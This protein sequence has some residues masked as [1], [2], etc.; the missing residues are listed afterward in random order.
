[1][2]SLVADILMP[3]IGLLLGSGQF[4]KSVPQPLRA[5]PNATLAEAKEAGAATNQL[6]AVPQHGDRVPHR[7][8]GGVL[9]IASLNRLYQAPPATPTTKACPYCI[10]VI[11]LA[12]SVP[13]APLISGRRET[14]AVLSVGRQ[15]G[16]AR[17]APMS[18]DRSVWQLCQP[19]S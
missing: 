14:D 11:P 7:G 10:A 13:S 6:R 9:L 18:A 4:S 3:P 1:V 16:N 15:S 12:A 17:A 8:L 5:S 2:S 19:R